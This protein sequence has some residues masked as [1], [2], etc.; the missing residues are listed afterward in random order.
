MD[1]NVVGLLRQVV[2]NFPGCR[3]ARCDV[4][5]DGA[6]PGRLVWFGMR[7]FSVRT[8]FDCGLHQ[9]RKM[10]TRELIHSRHK[11]PLLNDESLRLQNRTIIFLNIRYGR[12]LKSVFF[13]KKL[14]L[15]RPESCHIE[16]Y[17]FLEVVK[18]SAYKYRFSEKN[19]RVQ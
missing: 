2:H 14:L 16:S 11:K 18:N 5:V 6:T 15:D 7:T 17:K 1:Q 12:V 19:H 9:S 10:T 3:S 8:D 13:I 4:G